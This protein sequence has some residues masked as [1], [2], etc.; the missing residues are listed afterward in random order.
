MDI[1]ELVTFVAHGADKWEC[2]FPHNEPKYDD[3]P[4]EF[5][6]SGST[7]GDNM[8]A[9]VSTSNNPKVSLNPDANIKPAERPGH[10][11]SK[12]PGEPVEHWRPVQ[13][14]N[15]YHAGRIDRWPV[16]CAAHHLIPAQA[17][18]RDSALLG[19]LIKQGKPDKV[20][21]SKRQYTKDGYLL[22]SVGYN[23]NGAENGEWLPGPYAMRGV[24]SAF[25]AFPDE[26]DENPPDDSGL[27][28]D[29]AMP[30]DPS[31]QFDY[32]VVTMKKAWGQFHDAHP[33]YS[34]VVK[35]A[36]NTIAAKMVESSDAAFC[37]ECPDRKEDDPLPPP[38][39]LLARL[40][41]ISKRL[42][43]RVSGTPSSWH[44]D[45]FTSKKALEY[46]NRP[47]HKPD[48]ND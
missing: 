30:E 4:N 46:M 31:T 36:L 25:N 3:Y 8:A 15:P 23:V 33:D 28:P 5:M 45:L 43:F 47:S 2:P 35:L 44:P 18:L 41:G 14:E 13:L 21:T 42:W 29:A 1:G 24:W 7:L 39:Y 27:S 16:T 9:R 38:H 6:G 19:Y 34:K 12:L 22:A 11:L 10:K 40:N 26:E 37:E 20:K 17:S 48:H 32:A